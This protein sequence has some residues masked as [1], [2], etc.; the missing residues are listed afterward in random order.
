[1]IRSVSKLLHECAGCLLKQRETSRGNDAYI[2]ELENNIKQLRSGHPLQ[3]QSPAFWTESMP[4]SMPNASKSAS[5]WD[6]CNDLHFLGGISITLQSEEQSFV[7]H[8]Y[9]LADP[10]SIFFSPPPAHNSIIPNNLPIFPSFRFLSSS[11][12]SKC[13]ALRS[14]SNVSG[15]Q[16]TPCVIASPIHPYTDI[17]SLIAPGGGCVV[18][19]SPGGGCVVMKSPIPNGCAVTRTPGAGCDIMKRSPGG[20]CVVMKSPGS[21]CVVMNRE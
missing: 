18:M 15:L 14:R 10:A 21:G 2:H 17:S 11:Q 4:S 7:E 12:S 20:G 6:I 8:K 3:A 9:Q 5:Q 16:S 1:M 19:K 13:L